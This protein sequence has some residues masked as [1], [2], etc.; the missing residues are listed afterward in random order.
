[1]VYGTCVLFSCSTGC[2]E[3]K[4]QFHV[5]S[6]FCL[7]DSLVKPVLELH[8]DTKHDRQDDEPPSSTIG[9]FWELKI[10]TRHQK[11]FD[12]TTLC[13]RLIFKIDMQL[14]NDFFPNFHLWNSRGV[15]WGVSRQFRLW[16]YCWASQYDRRKHP[17]I[18]WGIWTTSNT[19]RP[20]WKFKIQTRHQKSI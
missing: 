16:Y 8:I 7:L 2:G 5:N 19:M 11:R 17:T 13:L 18:V 10:K 1:M 9:L 15:S 12:H 20:F 3:G 4:T 14:Q 6:P